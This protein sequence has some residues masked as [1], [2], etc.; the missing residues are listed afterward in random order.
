MSDAAEGTTSIF[1][2]RF[3][4]VS[5]TV[6]FNPF[7]SDVAFAMSSPTFFGDNP[8]GPILGA[9]EDVAPTSPP[10]TLKYTIVMA[11]GSN[12]GPIF[13]CGCCWFDGSSSLNISDYM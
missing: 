11:V 2:C 4:I 10:T 8:S 1:A 3:W 12:F 13:S 7:Q 6:I 5:E 9:K